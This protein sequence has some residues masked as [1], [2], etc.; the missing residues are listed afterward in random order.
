VQTLRDFIEKINIR[1]KVTWNEPMSRHTTFGIG[2]PADALV[3]PADAE[4]AARLLSAARAEGVGLF[5]LGGG[6]NVLVGD[7]GI[8]GIVMDTGA[9]RSARVEAASG[10]APAPAGAREA[11]LVAGAGLAI[12]E[13]C[14]EALALGLGGLEDFYGMPGSVGGAV[15]MNARCY[16]REMS[17]VLAWV[18]STPG[19]ETTRGVETTDGEG[20]AARRTVGAGPG[21]TAAGEGWG[22]KRS[23]YQIGGAAAGGG[24]PPGEA[25]GELVLEAGFRLTRL[26]DDGAARAAAAMRARRAD[27]EAKGHYRL[28]S[29]GSVFKNDRSLGAPTG[30]LLDGLGLR[31][32]SI[33][34]AMVSPWHANIF[35]NSGGATASDMR[36]LID[37]ARDEARK[38]LGAEL[39][40]EVLMVGEF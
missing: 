11:I 21:G 38:A 27:R 25:A 6:A 10:E 39:E 7:K 35:V 13:L 37:L 14:L 5:V 19:V 32:R 24:A 31:G 36:A 8:R 9:L 1:A 29:A 20:R 28:P 22:Y 2:G 26:D 23:P 30:K 16:E 12:D 40:S 4:S 3:R 17:Q 18:A 34:G 15:Y 33:G